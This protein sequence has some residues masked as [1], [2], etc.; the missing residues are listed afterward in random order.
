MICKEQ[1]CH[2]FSV[3]TVITFLPSHHLLFFWLCRRTMRFWWQDL[4][5]KVTPWVTFLEFDLRWSKWQM[6]PCLHS[7]KARR[8][9]PDHKQL[10]QRRK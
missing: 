1:N 5:V 4:D 7:T 9:D 6:C 8:R 3:Y 10:A 2:P